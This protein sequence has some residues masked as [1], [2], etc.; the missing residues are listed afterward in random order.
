M[1][2]AIFGAALQIVTLRPLI[3]RDPLNTILVTF[4]ISLVL[5]NYALWQFGPSSRKISEPITG[6]FILFYLEYPW[7]RSSSPR[8]RPRSS[9]ASGC[10]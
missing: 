3:G 5:Q 8:C 6:H 4:G 1:L 10:S 9:A 7:Y 2:V